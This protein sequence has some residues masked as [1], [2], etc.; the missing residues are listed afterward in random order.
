MRRVLGMKATTVRNVNS[1]ETV[2]V[3]RT[4]EGHWYADSSVQPE[5]EWLGGP[6]KASYW[7]AVRLNNGWVNE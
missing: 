2:K 3:F 7:V 4:R 6:R 5:L 1:G